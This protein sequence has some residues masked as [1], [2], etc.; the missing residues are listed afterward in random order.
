MNKTILNLG[1]W[2][3]I[4]CLTSFII[5]IIAF[6]GI[7]IQSPLFYWTNLKE[8]IEYVNTNSQFFQYLAKFFM[9]IF[10][11]AYM[12]LAIVFYEFANTEKKILVKIA[13]AFAIMFAILSSVQYFIEITAIRFALTENN[14]EGLEHFLYAK[15]TSI[16]TSVNML[17]WTFF[18]GLS[19]LFLYLGLFLQPKTKWIKIGF[20]INAISCILAGVGYS[21][22]I[23]FITFLFIN[24]GLGVG[25]L[26]L[27][28]SAYR[29][30]L[31]LKRK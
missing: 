3:A 11:L 19:S 22:Q 27:S 24:L 4:I 10:S 6:A 17:G 14:Y 8:Y 23:D 2:S 5:W 29:Y 9:I 20:L 15:P 26:T 18:L 31:R 30:F 21:F 25:T 1:L 7:A 13:I 12:V 28:I 16:I